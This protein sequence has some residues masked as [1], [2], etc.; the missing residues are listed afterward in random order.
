M[1]NELRAIVVN[2]TPGYAI[3]VDDMVLDEFDHVAS[4]DFS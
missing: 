1:A 3:S 2:D 4:L